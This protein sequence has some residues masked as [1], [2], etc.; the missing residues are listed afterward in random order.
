LPNTY[1]HH[2]YFKFINAHL[3]V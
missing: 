2:I 1:L 3:G